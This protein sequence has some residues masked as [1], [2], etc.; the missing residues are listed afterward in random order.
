MKNHLLRWSL[1]GYTTCL[2]AD[3][4]LNIGGQHKINSVVI[5]SPTYCFVCTL[6]KK[7]AYL[8]LIYCGSQLTSDSRIFCLCLPSTEIDLF[9]YCI[10]RTTVKRECKLANQ[11]PLMAIP[12]LDVAWPHLIPFRYL[13]VHGRK[14]ATQRRTLAWLGAGES[15]LCGLN[16]EQ[17][18]RFLQGPSTSRKQRFTLMLALDTMI[19]QEF[20]HNSVCENTPWHTCGTRRVQSARVSSLLPSAGFWGWTQVDRLVE[21][22][23]THWVI[24]PAQDTSSECWECR[25]LLVCTTPCF[26]SSTSIPNRHAQLGVQKQF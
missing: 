10:L 12:S 4:M 3:P 13:R 16:L 1:I 20:R 8:L 23:L 6:K 2:R 26:S 9:V 14:I 21:S 25:S 7:K 19:P 24:L 11:P 18:R 5:W 15:S 17:S 22:T